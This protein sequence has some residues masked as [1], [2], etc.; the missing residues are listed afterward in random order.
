MWQI[1][2]GEMK[3]KK[4]HNYNHCWA[5][6]AHTTDRLEIVTA[7]TSLKHDEKTTKEQKEEA[8]KTCNAKNEAAFSGE[9]EKTLKEALN[10][11]KKQN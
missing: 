10:A 7:T 9:F 2:K 8:E 5:N 6:L 3:Q 1:E 4:H 11:K